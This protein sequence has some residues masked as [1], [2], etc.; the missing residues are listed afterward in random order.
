MILVQT[1]DQGLHFPRLVPMLRLS[2]F[3]MAEI[4]QMINSFFAN[5]LNNEALK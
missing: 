4:S 5:Q 1:C 2:P 3:G